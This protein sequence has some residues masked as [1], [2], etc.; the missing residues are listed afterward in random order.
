MMYNPTKESCNDV[1]RYKGKLV[2]CIPLQRKVGILM[3][4]ATKE[5]WHDV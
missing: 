4:N 3:F 2:W 1:L 5:N